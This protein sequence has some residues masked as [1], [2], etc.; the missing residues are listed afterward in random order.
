MSLS[1]KLSTSTE[2]FTV[3]TEPSRADSTLVFFSADL[4]IPQVAAALAVELVLTVGEMFSR[5]LYLSLL[6]EEEEA[7]AR[8]RGFDFLSTPNKDMP[9]PQGVD[10]AIFDAA[11]GGNVDVLK[12]LVEMWAGNTQAIDGYK[13]GVS[14]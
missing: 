10:K 14:L 4:A 6:L 13:D 12:P 11:Q 5:S 8:A 2:A 9:V 1:G 7:A 3:R